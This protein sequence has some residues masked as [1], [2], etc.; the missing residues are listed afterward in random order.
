MSKSDKKLRDQINAKPQRAKP[1]RAS[2]ATKTEA[3]DDTGTT[4][5]T[6]RGPRVKIAPGSTPSQVLQAHMTDEKQLYGACVLDKADGDNPTKHTFNALAKRIDGL[7]KKVGEKAVNMIRNRSNPGGVQVY[8][9]IALDHLIE[10]GKMTS[11]SLRGVYAGRSA[12]GGPYKTGTQSAQANQ[13]MQL[14]P[15]LGIA[16]RS[17]D[18]STL[19]LNKGSAIVADYR[20]ASK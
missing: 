20:K 7:A 17:E 15:A 13:I 12:Y 18:K 11:A 5:G 16:E 2:V 4:E 8:T 19:T 3:N 10:Q 14:F 9:R 1:A 6:K